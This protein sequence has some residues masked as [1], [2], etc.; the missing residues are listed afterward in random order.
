MPVLSGRVVAAS[1]TRVWVGSRTPLVAGSGARGLPVAYRFDVRAA[2]RTGG[3]AST[4]PS[5]SA[6]AFLRYPGFRI[7]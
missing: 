2:V 1:P 5:R 3:C 4:E 7:P 6:R